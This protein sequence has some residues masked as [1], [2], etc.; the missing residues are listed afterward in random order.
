MLAPVVDPVQLWNVGWLLE[1][2]RANRRLR[3]IVWLRQRLETAQLD[4]ALTRLLTAGYET[5][6]LHHLYEHDRRLF[7]DQDIVGGP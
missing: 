5:A 1:Q 4:E 6:D 7:N 2:L 3:A